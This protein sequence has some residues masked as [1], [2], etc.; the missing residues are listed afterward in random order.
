MKVQTKYNRVIKTLKEG[1]F[2]SA[3]CILA[4]LRE[5]YDDM[6]CLLV[7]KYYNPKT[8]WT[9]RQTIDLIDTACMSFGRTVYSDM[10]YQAGVSGMVDGVEFCNLDLY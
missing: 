1:N 6:V 10:K 9:T 7:E 5:D 8:R 2:T 4:D 3:W